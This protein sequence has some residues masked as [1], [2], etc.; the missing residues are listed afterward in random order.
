MVI[1][2]KRTCLLTRGAR[3]LESPLIGDFTAFISFPFSR[4]WAGNQR[5][6]SKLFLLFSKQICHSDMVD[7]EPNGARKI[8]HYFGFQ[9]ARCCF[10][11][12]SK[13]CQHYI[14]LKFKSC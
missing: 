6:F 7:C 12:F 10:T 1:R 13:Y 14:N 5:S 9:R 3:V 8:S 4:A 11:T 2:E